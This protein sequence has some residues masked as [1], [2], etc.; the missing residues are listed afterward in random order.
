M[1]FTLNTRIRPSV[2]RTGRTNRPVRGKRY[3]T[4]RENEMEYVIV[5]VAFGV[6]GFVAGGLV[7]WKHRD[8][9]AKILA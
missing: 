7:V 4:H 5:A 8:R 6:V 2:G 3:F 1:E 9:I